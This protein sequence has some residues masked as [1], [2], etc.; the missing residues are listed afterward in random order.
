LADV[1]IKQLR[2]AADKAETDLALV[3]LDAIAD[4]LEAEA[5]PVESDGIEE[6]ATKHEPRYFEAM[7]RC[8][9][10]LTWEQQNDWGPIKTEVFDKLATAVESDGIEEAE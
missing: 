7:E 10:D 6:A 1:R 8:P 2:R 3:V 9:T 5:K 4:Q